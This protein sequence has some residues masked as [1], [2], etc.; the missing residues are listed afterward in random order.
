MVGGFELAGWLVMGVRAVVKA[1]VSE[2][3]AEPFVKNRK[4]RAT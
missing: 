3:A 2:R 4:S 1:A